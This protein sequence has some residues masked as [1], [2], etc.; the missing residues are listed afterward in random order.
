[1]PGTNTLQMGRS[2][3]RDEPSRSLEEFGTLGKMRAIYTEP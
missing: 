3:R 1:M 2:C